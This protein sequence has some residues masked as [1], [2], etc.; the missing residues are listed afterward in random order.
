[1]NVVLGGRERANWPGSCRDIGI[2]WDARSASRV[3]GSS[4]AELREWFQEAMNV[5]NSAIRVRLFFE[6]PERAECGVAFVPLG[7]NTLG[8]SHLADNTCRGGKRQ[9]YD[10]RRW[11]RALF[12]QTVLHELGHLLGL[13]HIRGKRVMNPIILTDIV[14]LTVSDVEQAVRLGYTRRLEDEQPPEPAP[15]PDDSPE[16]E[17][18]RMDWIA[19]IRVLLDMFDDGG[20]CRDRALNREG[21]KIRRAFAVRRAARLAGVPLSSL[22]G[23]PEYHAFVWDGFDLSDVDDARQLVSEFE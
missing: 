7:G 3:P 14:G 8:W 5:W 22:R 2:S 23:T 15:L 12:R 6:S 9:R 21:G 10:I 20:I 1:M 17:G 13:G 18:P 11:S 16:P 4:E 19:V